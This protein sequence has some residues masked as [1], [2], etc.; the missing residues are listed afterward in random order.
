MGNWA[1]ATNQGSAVGR[2]MSG[3]KTVFET[4]SSYS[5][6]FFSPPTGGS[7]TFI[8]VTDSKFA[9]EIISRGSVDAGKMTQIYIKSISNIT[10]IIGA[11]VINAPNEVS[12]LTTAIKSKIDISTNKDQLFDLNFDLKNLTS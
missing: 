2:T 9:D 11:T 3:T 10:R 4:A 1:N 6:N 8:G 5:I 7:C 12:P